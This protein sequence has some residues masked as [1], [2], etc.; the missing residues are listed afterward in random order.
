[1]FNLAATQ[2]LP[3]AKPF[4]PFR[5]V[6]SDGGVV[7]VPSREMVIAGRTFAVVGVPD[8]RRNETVADVW[9]T[10]WYMHVSRI[11]MLQPGAPPFM[12]PPAEPAGS[13]SV[14]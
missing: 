7:T 10:V 2:A 13:P 9:T 8:P 4:A 14:A 3:N 12:G 6:T 5:F 11:E 1:M